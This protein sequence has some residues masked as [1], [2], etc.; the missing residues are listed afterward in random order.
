MMAQPATAPD[1]SLNRHDFFY[2]GQSKQRRMFI[3]KDG[4]V[5]WSYKDQLRRGEISDAVLMT[6]GHMLVAH[7]YGIAEIDQDGQTLWGY[8]A[9]EG[10]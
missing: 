2:A 5:S 9:P 8:Q 10:T 4:Q 7:Q 6:D 1:E 3:V